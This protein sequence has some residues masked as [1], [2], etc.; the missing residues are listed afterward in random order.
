MDLESRPDR[1]KPAPQAEDSAK[2]LR[3]AEELFHRA[4]DLPAEQRVAAVT[5]WCGDDLEFRESVLALLS[6]ADSVQD[7]ISA[8]ASSNWTSM[9]RRESGG[10]TDGLDNVLD[11]SFQATDPELQETAVDP[12]LG[13][14]LG[15]YR[16][17]RLL[18]RGGMG[19]VYLADRISGGFK[20]TVAVKLMAW[21]VRSAP[22][23]QQFLLERQTLASLEH[24]NIARLLDGGVTAEGFP[25]VVMEYVEGR[26]LDEACDDPKTS[27]DQVIRW[28]LQLSEAV[29]YVHRNLILHRDLKPGNVMVTADG[30]VKLLDFGAFKRLGPEADSES[31]MTQAGLRPVTVRY[32]SPE[33]IEGAG[34]ST[35]SDVYSLGMILYRLLAGR[36]P[37]ELNDLT[38]GRYLE[39]LRQNPYKAPSLVREKSFPVEARSPLDAETARDLD[40]ITAK[41]IRFEAEARYPTVGA[42]ADDLV[43]I[44]DHQPVSARGDDVRYRAGKF[45]R[46]HRWPIV[47]T[48]C[49]LLV[50]L[51]GTMVIAWQGHVA[52]ME[53]RRAERGIEDERQLAHMLLF[54]YFE[55]LT[56]IPGSIDAQRKAVA[57][58]LTYLDR[59]AQISPDPA[60]ELDTI[61]GYTDMGNLLGNP[62]SQ[63]L[64]NVAEA[65]TTLEKGQAMTRKR[66]N[67]S[68]RD[69]ESL[70]AL[71]SIDRALGGIY[72][73]NGDAKRAQAILQEAATAS[74]AMALDPHS[75]AQMMQHAAA[76]TDIL[77][78]V[79]DP[80]RGMITADLARAEQTYLLSN[81]YDE[82]CRQLDPNNGLCRSGTIV[83]EYKLGSLVEDPDPA[84]A[85]LHYQKGL[86]ILAQFTEA[87]KKLPRS[88]RL[89]NY[90]GSRLGLVEM[91]LGH[92]AEGEAEAHQAQQSF[93]DA[94]AKADL[95]NRARFDMAAFETDLATEYHSE[96]KD[97]EASDTSR[98]LLNIMAVLLQRS[99]RNV[100]WQMIQAQDLITAGKIETALGHGAQAKELGR[101]GLSEAVQ[102]A[103][104]KDASPEAL[105]LAADGLLEAHPNPEEAVQA[106]RFAQR[107]VDA[108][109]R[110]MPA[111]LITLAKAQAAAGHAR[112]AAKTAQQ[113]LSELSAS[114]VSSSQSKLIAD[115]VAEARR[116]AR[117]N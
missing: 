74:A 109:A 16:L 116:L 87:E 47:A 10:L 72:L 4:L 50:I 82:K 40:A 42:L 80:G 113:A 65:I 9:L 57:E 51:T 100:R 88:I 34:V 71:T 60:L 68:P 75:T 103:E 114:N 6:A 98:E 35:A 3:R 78:D 102:L 28:M 39:R 25:Y 73:G 117:V 79:Y 44:L 69:L 66:L 7:L 20:Q 52:R 99:P 77:G 92:A 83:G 30:V 36:L 64:G 33:H 18:G 55:E 2:R 43:R 19:V 46:R 105:D 31:A 106:L 81:A 26:R 86:G 45:W 115:Q 22:A 67:R 13:R 63:N 11:A 41:A 5:G 91:R 15:A 94:I 49:V 95:D 53:E 12:W 111:Q 56:L 24:R 104:A 29:T 110:P 61:R 101:R 54:D 14:V 38:I 62:Y 17:E 23:V 90:L 58:A 108:N 59:L 32:A 97:A 8:S 48:A 27:I 85:M 70:D 107:A 112:D 21:H 1:E 96:G 89:Q 93:R 37:Q 76:A 84:M